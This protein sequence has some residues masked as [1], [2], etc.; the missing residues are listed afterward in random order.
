MLPNE[1]KH[2]FAPDNLILRETKS[3]LLK[4]ESPGKPGLLFFRDKYEEN[5]CMT[6][7]LVVVWPPFLT[8][9]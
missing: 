7:F 2:L 6:I 8:C 9:I 4:K 5:Y 3:D 1:V